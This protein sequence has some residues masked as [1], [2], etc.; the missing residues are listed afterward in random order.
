MTAASRARTDRD[1]THWQ[2]GRL[3]LTGEKPAM[4]EDDD[5]LQDLI[6]GDTATRETRCGFDADSEAGQRRLALIREAAGRIS[7]GRKGVRQ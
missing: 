2:G 4:P 6:A 7:Q 1:P 5:A 3:L